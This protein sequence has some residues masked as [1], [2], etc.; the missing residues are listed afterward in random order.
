MDSLDGTLAIL[1]NKKTLFGNYFDAVTDRY[2]ELIFYIGFAISGFY[3]ETFF[4]ATG[5]MMISYVK[6]RTALTIKID[7]VD[8]PA[9]GEMLDRLSLLIIGMTLAVFL[10]QVLNFS[11]ISLTLWFIALVTN[12]GAIQRIFYA[13]NLIRKYQANN[14]Q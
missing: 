2:R 14:V 9:I 6:A 7:N 12:I 4:A 11:T 3:L 8:W 5:S 1:S 13:K 10:P